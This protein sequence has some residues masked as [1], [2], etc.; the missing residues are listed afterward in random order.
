MR[1]S[2]L[3]AIVIAFFM[4]GAPARAQEPTPQA[5][6]DT[7]AV[8]PVETFNLTHENR[9]YQIN[10]FR[11]PAGEGPTGVPRAYVLD[12]ERL[13]APL[14]DR[15]R[16]DFPRWRSTG[17]IIGITRTDAAPEGSARYRDE[18]A[19]SLGRFLIDALQPEIDRRFGDSV[20]RQ[21]LAGE[22][23]A[24][25]FVLHMA[26]DS[27]EAFDAYAA[28]GPQLNRHL[29]DDIAEGGGAVYMSSVRWMG[30]PLDRFEALAVR[31][32]DAG[33]E[34][35][36]DTSPEGWDT[37]DGVEALWAWIGPYFIPPPV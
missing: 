27:P 30:R 17:V 21:T 9:T 35:Q 4:A 13:A 32:E 23:D 36:V 6:A 26:A 20:S 29:P 12:G 2:S 28:H 24:A 10:I 1:L 25:L 37:S 3:S 34:I 31:F 8:A 33:R 18:E 7:A 16:Q 11:L 15:L 14:A 19:A 22:G 5:E